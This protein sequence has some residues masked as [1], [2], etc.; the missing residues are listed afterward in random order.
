MSKKIVLGNIN[1]ATNRVD[2]FKILE[3][4]FASKAG[5]RRGEFYLKLNF[6]NSK[7]ILSRAK[8]AMGGEKAEEKGGSA[9]RKQVFFTKDLLKPNSSCFLIFYKR[10]IETKL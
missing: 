10:F 6:Q 3:I 4:F 2:L 5:D 9:G 1:N 7:M 8:P